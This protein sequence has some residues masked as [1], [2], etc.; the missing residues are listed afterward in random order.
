[1]ALEVY[2]EEDSHE[3]LRD[4]SY[5]DWLEEDHQRQ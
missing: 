1:M 3:L 4:T 5:T 2:A